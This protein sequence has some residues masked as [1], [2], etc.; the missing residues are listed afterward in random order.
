MNV[1][2]PGKSF[3]SSATAAPSLSFLNDEPAK[4]NAEVG[5]FGKV[6]GFGSLV[7]VFTLVDEAVAAAEVEGIKKGTAGV[8]VEGSE[9]VGCDL[10]DEEV[11]V[12]EGAVEAFDVE[13]GA[14][15]ENVLDAAGAAVD[16]DAV[17]EAADGSPAKDEVEEGAFF[18]SASTFVRCPLYFSS[19]ALRRGPTSTKASFSS[20]LLIAE[21]NSAFSET[22]R[23]RRD[24]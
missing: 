24:R 4:E 13:D 20:S 9:K 3:L 19:I 18:L 21:D 17:E 5:A 23:P 11:D 16:D 7:V 12:A 8:V 6:G 14:V 1:G 22:L 15:N 10:A 2:C